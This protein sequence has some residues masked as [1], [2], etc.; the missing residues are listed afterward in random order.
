[1]PD[2]I[3]KGSSEPFSDELFPKTD[4][5]AAILIADSRAAA[6]FSMG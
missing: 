5:S 3:K 6:D 1:M 2:T 4:T